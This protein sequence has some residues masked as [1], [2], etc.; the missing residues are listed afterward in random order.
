MALQSSGQITLQNIATEFGGTAPHSLTE[1]YAAA[2]GI[3]ASGVIS[4]QDFYGASAIT[5]WIADIT[6]GQK[7]AQYVTWRGYSTVQSIGSITDNT[8]DNLSG[9][10]VRQF[11]SLNNSTLYFEVNGNYSNSGWTSIDA[12]PYNFTRASAGYNYNS[13]NN[14]TQW[15]WSSISSTDPF[16]VSNDTVVSVEMNP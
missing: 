3:P 7:T 6:K 9:A 4:I 8:V 1:Y 10:T 15:Y 2:T 16:F 5:N 12:G 14:F 13:S 11:A